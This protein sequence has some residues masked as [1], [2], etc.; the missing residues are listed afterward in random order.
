MSLR[1]FIR[2]TL[3]LKASAKP[4][5]RRAYSYATSTSYQGMNQDYRWFRQDELIRR[6][7]ATNALFATA[8]GF[9]TTLES[10]GP[11]DYASI[12]E[13]VDETNKRV[14]LDKALHDA[15]VKRSIH[16][17]AAYE[18]V[19]NSRELPQRLIPLSST[20]IRPDLDEH[21]SHTGFTYQGQRGFY[22]PE[23]VLYL[24]NLDLEADYV[25]L[26]DVEPV[27]AV[28]EARHCILRENLPE[29]ARTLWAPYVILKADTSGLT[30]DEAEATVTRLAEVARA[31]KSIAVNES[32]EATT[33]NITP[34]IE[35]LNGLLDKLEEAI[36]AN[37]G[38]P[39]FLLGR[40]IE[41]RA[42]AYAELE[43]YVQGTVGSIQRYLKREVERQL[44]DP[45][46]RLILVEE[47]RPTD[48]Q[49]VHVKHRWNPVR[50]TDVYQIADA[51]A[52]LWGSGSGPIAGDRAKAWELM[53][54]D[55]AELEER[56]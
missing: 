35:G 15:Q 42:T 11:D 40:P 12:K 28:L 17:R 10:E 36:I 54:W 51:A 34:D 5:A 23:E 13:A 44:Y 2:R 22:K 47:G 39:R 6:C 45:I 3:G 7:V 32:V 24:T 43:A 31:G 18:I 25:G 38:T 41:N 49:P 46:T 8:S 33:V 55:P 9:E 4:K 37:F 26:S 52:K 29:I 53:G 1:T 14:N 48:P 20:Q 30:E 19:R 21:W 16:G 56:P 27:R 50:V